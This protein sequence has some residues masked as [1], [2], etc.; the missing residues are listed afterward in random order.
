MKKWAPL[1]MFVLICAQ[2]FLTVGIENTGWLPKS[3]MAFSIVACC[4]NTV[5]MYKIF[6]MTSSAKENV[7]R[8]AIVREKMRL[9]FAEQQFDATEALAFYCANIISF[10]LVNK[11][12]AE[13]LNIFLEDIKQTYQERISNE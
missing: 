5:M 6:S 9:A 7:E 3:M 4:F 8:L 11:F 13:D 1:I 12:S 2:I 10:A